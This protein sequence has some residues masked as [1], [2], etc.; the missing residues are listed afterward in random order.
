MSRPPRVSVLLPARD[1][2]RFIGAAVASILA[3][4]VRDF[5]LLVLDDGST[6]ETVAVV[7]SFGDSRIQLVSGAPRGLVA[8]LNDGLEQARGAFIAR[9][10]A[11]DEA[12]PERF[13]RQLLLFDRN[14]DVGI[15]GSALRAMDEQGLEGDLL[16]VACGD[17]EIRWTGLLTTPF[18]HPTVMLRRE[19]VE[20]T[21][22]RYDP[23]WNTV[24]D[25][26]LWM[27]LL[28]H[29]R[30]D[31]HPEP[32]LRY[33]IHGGSVTRERRAAQLAL[34][35]DVAGAS[36]ERT[37]PGFPIEPGEISR[38]RRVFVSRAPGEPV[39]EAPERIAAGHGLLRLLEEFLRRKGG[40][41]PDAAAGLAARQAARVARV[42]LTGP[43]PGWKTLVD[44]L[45]ALDPA[46]PWNLL[47]GLPLARRPGPRA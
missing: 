40:A 6:D 35:D 20:R 12:L 13:E 44:R 27:R 39:P 38:L 30:G 23:R 29:T 47:A 11:D 2:G 31:N 42:A 41:D 32:L 7:R 26:E 33:R 28:E 4:T 1:A 36:I 16:P 34:H 22:A 25:Y 46:L 15:A 37:L 24:E 43:A 3:Q 8:V 17:L 19:L 14:P 10:D 18:A 5:E 9:M 21:G 45:L